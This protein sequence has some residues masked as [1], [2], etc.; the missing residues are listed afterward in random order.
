M[1]SDW[2]T[3]YFDNTYWLLNLEMYKNAVKSKAH[4][5]NNSVYYDRILQKLEKLGVKRMLDERTHSKNKNHKKKSKEKGKSK[6][7][8]GFICI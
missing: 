6:L 5:K 1:T 4:S 3:L 7:I 8:Q 2:P